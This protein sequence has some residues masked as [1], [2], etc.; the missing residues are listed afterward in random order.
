MK[1]Y[2]MYNPTD[3]PW[4]SKLP[5]HW[6]TNRLK[7]LLAERKES[8]NPVKT[9]D[10]LSLTNTRGVIPYALKG[11]VGN[12][13][14]EN[15]EDY[16]LAYPD[17]LVLNS[18]NVIIGSVGLSKYFGAVSPVYYMLYPRGNDSIRY[19]EYIFKLKTIQEY[20]KGLGNGILAIRMRI[21]MIKLNNVLLPNP[22]REE[23]DQIV[24]YLDWKVSKTNKLISALKKQ[25]ALLN[26]QKQAVINEAVTKGLDPSVPMKDSCA[27]WIGEIPTTWS[28]RRLKSIV[29][30][31]SDKRM[32]D[33]DFYIGMENIQS[34]TGKYIETKEAK[35][36]S[37]C[38]TFRPGDVLF[39]KL[40]PYLAKVFLTD[41][42]GT[43]SNEFLI[44]HD[45]EGC[46]RYLYYLLLC[47]KF[48]QLVNASTYGAKMPR[49]NWSFIGNCT[50]PNPCEEEQKE[51]ADFLDSQSAKI[52][53]LIENI[54]REITVLGE[55]RTR[56]ISDVVTGQIDV[57][58]VEVPDFEYISDEAEDASDDENTDDEE[59]VEEEE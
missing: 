18:M 33:N 53:A 34:W 30:L 2:E 26:E 46:T 44:L 13:S 35:P 15:L 56:L 21:P 50:V 38:G 39:G 52:D 37:I 8:N 31:S 20:L 28:V 27:D 54:N 23:Q 43:S 45:Y 51:I 11:N 41:C 42:E 36:E 16:K 59:T 22:P 17:D 19:Y 7:E 57:R 48:I 14:K 5:T 32:W 3:V 9:T 12:K 25:I 4:I 40:R 29:K 58:A 55:Y 24:R 6:T 47:Y 49:A 10:I 1:S